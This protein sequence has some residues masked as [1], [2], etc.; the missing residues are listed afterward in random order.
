MW[1]P[2]RLHT[3]QLA[4]HES[5]TMSWSNQEQMRT[6]SRVCLVAVSNSLRGLSVLYKWLPSM[7]EIFLLQ[8]VFS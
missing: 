1:T 5:S 4:K 3:P 7:T 6:L 2:H 8:D